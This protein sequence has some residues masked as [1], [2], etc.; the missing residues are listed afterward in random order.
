M[1][2]GMGRNFHI[3]ISERGTPEA[4]ISGLGKNI[5]RA[6]FSIAF[7]INYSTHTYSKCYAPITN[8]S[9]T[10]VQLSKS[11]F[12]RL[13]RIRVLHQPII[14]V[15]QIAD[16]IPLPAKLLNRLFAILSFWRKILQVEGT[17]HFSKQDIPRISCYPTFPANRTSNS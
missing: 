17:T 9:N 6:D 13:A 15:F 5:S 3:G 2:Y 8:D 10:E 11:P 1:V 7:S 12:N 4:P 14:L 16:T